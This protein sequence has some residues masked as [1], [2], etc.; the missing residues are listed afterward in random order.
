MVLCS[1]FYSGVFCNMEKTIFFDNAAAVKPYDE[2]L[3]CFA[4]ESRTH[5]ANSEAV[6]LLAY[7]ARKA[8]DEAAERLSSVLTGSRAHPVIWGNSATELF[9]IAASFPEFVSSRATALEHPALTANLKKFTA[10]SRI[11][12]TSEA[13]PDFSN[14]TEKAGLCAVFQVQSELGII[15]NTEKLFSG[16]NAR[17][18]LTDAVQAAGKMPTDKNADIIIISGVKFGS[19]GG[20]AMLLAPEGEFT[21]KLL[22]HAE[23]MRKTDY[24]LSRVSVPLM[25]AMTL[26]AE[27]AVS[28]MSERTKRISGLNTLIRD[29]VQ[30]FGIVPTLPPGTAVSPYILNLMLPTQ[31]AAVVVRALGQLNIFTAAGSAC[32]AETDTPSPALGAIGIK[33]TKAFRALRLCFWEENSYEDG[34]IFLSGLE[35]VLKNY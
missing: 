8:L 33:G 34:K 20:A 14:C 11:P 18:L 21:A 28:K 29:G 24:A 16:A 9:R 23:K 22:E 7:Q 31:E 35:N 4:A 12:V 5:Y 19:P 6:N 27:I 10:Y 30:K 13:E 1:I 26:A 17:C 3:E 15:Q 25:R 32:S 2:A